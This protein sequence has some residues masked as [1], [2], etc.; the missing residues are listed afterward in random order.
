MGDGWQ[1]AGAGEKGR[2]KPVAKLPRCGIFI[3]EL[4]L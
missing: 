1:R 2:E 4:I 3:P